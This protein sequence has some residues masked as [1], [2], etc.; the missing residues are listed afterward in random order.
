M[1]MNRAGRGGK[2]EDEGSEGEI[3]GMERDMG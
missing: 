1:E 2:P 3:S